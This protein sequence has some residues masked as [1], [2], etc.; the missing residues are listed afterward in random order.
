MERDSKEDGLT[1]SVE[2]ISRRDR[3]LVDLLSQR[4]RLSN[5]ASLLLGDDFL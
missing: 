2:K 1:E 3:V 4:C 5:D